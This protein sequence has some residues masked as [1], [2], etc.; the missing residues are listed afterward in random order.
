MKVAELK[1]ILARESIADHH[2]LV[3]GE[4]YLPE[5]LIEVEQDGSLLFLHFDNAPEDIAGDEEG[6]GLVEHEI[7]LLK[8]RIYQILTERCSMQQKQH[9]LLALVLSGHEMSSSEFVALL[10]QLE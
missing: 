5:Q 3:T 2:D 4:V 9:A 10:E 6:R 1:K 7:E 8:E